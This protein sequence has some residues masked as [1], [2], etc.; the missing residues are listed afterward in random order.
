M[1]CELGLCRGD[2]IDSNPTL[3]THF[4]VNKIYYTR[5]SF[6]NIN[7]RMIVLFAL[8]LNEATRLDVRCETD[9]GDTRVSI[10]GRRF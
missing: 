10:G 3:K 4:Y 8:D 7:S 5:G 2:S 1:P 6:V 9:R